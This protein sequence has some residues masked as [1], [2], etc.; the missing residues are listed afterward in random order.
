MILQDAFT[1]EPWSLRETRLDLDLLAAFG[2]PVCHD[3]SPIGT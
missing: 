1:I 3:V 2:M